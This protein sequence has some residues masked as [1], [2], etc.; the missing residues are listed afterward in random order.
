MENRKAHHGFILKRQQ[1]LEELSAVLNYYTHEG[2]GAELL[3]IDRKDENMTF[4]IAFKT[5][6]ENDTGVFHILEHS[7][8]CGSDKYPVKEPFVELLKASLKT[9]LNAFTFPDK[10]MY[11]VCSRNKKDFLNLV[12]VYMDAVL[13]PLAKSK[14]EIF[15]QEGWHHEISSPD[16]PL[17][18]KGVVFNEMK[19]AYSSVD[20]LETTEAT[21][22]LYRGTVYGYDSGGDPRA[23][24]D[25]TY[26]NFCSAHDKFYHP[27]NAKI[28]LDGSIDLDAT[29]S[30][31]DSYL[32]SFERKEID[33]DIPQMKPLGF[34]E[35]TVYYEIGENESAEGKA[36]VCLGYLAS[37]FD[38]RRDR[39]AL[40]AIVDAIAGSN[41]APFKKALMSTGLIEDACFF[42][43]DGIAHNSI[44]LELKHL[45]EEDI[46][47]MLALAD[48]TLRDMVAAGFD[49]QLL[50]ASLSR[51]EFRAR[52]QDG[53]YP[54]GLAN[55]IGALDSWLYGG[56]PADALGFEEDFS[57]LRK[58]L[59]TDYYERLFERTVLNSQ[60]SVKITLLPSRTRGE[61]ILA[62]ERAR[63][64]REKAALTEDELSRKIEATERLESWQSTP[65]SKEALDTL[66]TLSVSDLSPLPQ[67]YEYSIGRIQ[68]TE[69]IFTPAASKGIVYA[70]LL[71]DISDLDGD[72]LFALSLLG[73]LFKNVG[74]GDLSAVEL[75]TRI[76]NDLGSL[77]FTINT[78]K[79]EQRVTPYVTA[80][81]SCLDSKKAEAVEIL[82]K[83]IHGS[84]IIGNKKIISDIIKQTVSI[85]KES[86]SSSGHSVAIGRIGAY[87]SVA[88]AVSEYTEG[89]E[90]YL[91]LKA[92]SE[93]PEGTLDGFLERLDGIRRSVFTR[94]RL[95]V[96]YS[97]RED[98]AFAQR[99]IGI[100]SSDG[101][102]PGELKLQPL[103]ARR[104]G[105]AVPSQVAYASI[106]ANMSDVFG[107]ERGP[108]AFPV[109]RSILSLGYL[110]NKVRVQGGAYGAGLTHRASGCVAFYS[111][112]DPSPA[113]SIEAYRHSGDYLRTLAESGDDISGFIIGAIGNADI[114][115]T[116]KILQVLSMKDYLS[117]DDYEK[118][119]ALRAE[120]LSTSKEDLLASAD[121]IDRLCENA[122]ICVVAGKEKLAECS[123]MLDSIIE[124]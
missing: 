12:D 84:H 99:L 75:Q 118:R 88:G 10:T 91:R 77:Y 6:P 124:I 67:K 113:K 16:M 82:E 15:Y 20:E 8:L 18:Y 79:R 25:L 48:S 115:L 1:P 81:I 28:I 45:K 119:K 66:P 17:S 105:I 49:R 122:G 64:D 4:A 37:R 96:F 123:E 19:G 30:L 13:H 27:S 54:A 111:Y 97:G 2:S 56:D 7:V 24:P 94:D 70:D 86:I 80:H 68:D 71:F 92:L 55:A 57:F 43:Y 107:D 106:G 65:D 103:G 41:E 83:I 42:P 3:F 117:G 61:E 9:F 14:P 22:L 93:N 53:Y 109:I 90:F 69:V 33:T 21:R 62:E 5:L 59:D 34:A 104:E 29:L 50:A 40:S 114:L 120:M 85:S 87:H 51:M 102:T 121:I 98:T 89:I 58:A 100:F 60:H 74:C 26:E 23:I 63:L 110:W 36:R 32:N 46:D 38:E 73:D 44:M 112:R 78:F 108:G 72:G 116:P 31:L 47:A 39:A 101:V 76:K 11:P 35:K 95:K 52:E